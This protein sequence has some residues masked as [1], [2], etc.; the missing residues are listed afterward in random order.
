MN[1]EG[2]VAL[3]DLEAGESA[4]GEREEAVVGPAKE[5]GVDGI[6]AEGGVFPL[7]EAIEGGAAALGKVEV[8]EGRGGQGGWGIRSQNAT[9]E[10][11]I[12]VLNSLGG[13]EQEGWAPTCD[14]VMH[15]LSLAA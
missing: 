6:D 2:H 11:G 1:A 7:D 8:D 5:A 15:R 12:R 14:G 10:I 3:Y 9:A 4:G 13:K